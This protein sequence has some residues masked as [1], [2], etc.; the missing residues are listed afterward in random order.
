[1]KISAGVCPLVATL[2]HR[3]RSSQGR[4]TDSRPLLAVP[5]SVA[6]SW[7]HCFASE[8]VLFRAFRPI[9]NLRLR[10][11]RLRTPRSIGLS[12]WTGIRPIVRRD[13]RRTEE[14]ATKLTGVRITDS[15]SDR[16]YVVSRLGVEFVASRRVSIGQT[17]RTGSVAL[18]AY[19]SSIG[20]NR[21][22]AVV[23]IARGDAYRRAWSAPLAT[24]DRA[25][26]GRAADRSVRHVSSHQSSHFESFKWNRIDGW[27]HARR[28]RR[29]ALHFPTTLRS[30]PSPLDC[31][32]DATRVPR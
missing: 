18:D 3:D 13:R 31:S 26:S 2:G 19:S 21:S 30:A 5:S 28:P 4:T 22:P 23:A 27:T 24:M 9:M 10:S 14:S 8:T 16:I 12:P 6:H 7:F 17:D 1:M 15:S 29:T 20:S 25:C 32:K 11:E